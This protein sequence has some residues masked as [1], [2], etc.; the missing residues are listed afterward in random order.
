M[1]LVFALAAAILAAIVTVLSKAGIKDIDSSLGFA[2]QSVIIIAISWVVVVAQGNTSQLA[3]I[4]KKTWI[5]LILAGIATTFSSLATFRALKLGD[6][7]V[8]NP[9]ER[10]S[11]V[12]A[13]ILAYLFLKERVT[14]Q[15]IGGAALM[16]I[17]AVIIALA[18][19]PS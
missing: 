16:A 11:L 18:K 6:A 8:V 9:I 3:R 15:I 14:W 19:K 1:W 13:I 17:G 10:V 7:S 5:F 4:D 12:F 2:I